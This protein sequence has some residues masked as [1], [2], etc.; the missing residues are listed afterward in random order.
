MDIALKH[1]S[2]LN[3]MNV[4]A[5]TRCLCNFIALIA[6]SV[7]EATGVC[8]SMYTTAGHI[9]GT[10]DQMLTWHVWDGHCNQTHEWTL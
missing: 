2:V 1:S 3:E 7:A 10:S 5:K 9:G 6:T 4:Y 8:G